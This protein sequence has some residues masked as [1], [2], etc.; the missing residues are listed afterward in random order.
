MA[1]WLKKVR[2][3][4]RTGQA[5][6]VGGCR[7]V[8]GGVKLGGRKPQVTKTISHCLAAEPETAGCA[9]ITVPTPR[10]SA[11]QKMRVRFDRKTIRAVRETM[12]RPVDDHA[13]ACQMRLADFGDNVAPAVDTAILWQA[14]DGMDC[15][16]RRR[17]AVTRRFVRCFPY[18]D[19]S[20]GVFQARPWGN[21]ARPK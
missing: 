3:A 1:D 14:T 13:P 11:D 6:S 8:A 19:P 2:T 17:P 5:T 15:G 12:D 21:S 20:I 4:A 9:W 10:A 18:S 7:T 16:W